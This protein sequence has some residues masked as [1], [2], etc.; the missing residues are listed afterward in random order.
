MF[1][2]AKKDGS[3]TLATHGIALLFYKPECRLS[4]SVWGKRWSRNIRLYGPKRLSF[5]ATKGYSSCLLPK[6]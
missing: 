3:W 6:D 4:V 1:T 5:E 2:F